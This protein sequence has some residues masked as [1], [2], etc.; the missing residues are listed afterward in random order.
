ML[1][2]ANAVKELW[3]RNSF[4]KEKVFRLGYFIL[5]LNEYHS[6]TI[7]R[8]NQNFKL[9]LIFSVTLILIFFFRFICSL[10][11]DVQGRV[12]IRT[13]SDRQKKGGMGMQKLDIFH[14]CHKCMVPNL[15]CWLHRSHFHQMPLI[16][17]TSWKNLLW[18]PSSFQL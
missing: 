9:F 1:I 18:N 12:P 8:M 2:N 11:F 15:Q 13:H 5:F 3:R 14:G 7:V 17:L 16:S 10:S 6:I 4:L